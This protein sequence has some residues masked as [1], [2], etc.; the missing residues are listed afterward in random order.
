MIPSSAARRRRAAR[1]RRDGCSSGS[2]S[3]DGEGGYDPRNIDGD[4]DERG[5]WVSLDRGACLA[6]PVRDGQS[7]AP[8]V[9]ICFFIADGTSS[10]NEDGPLPLPVLRQQMSARPWRVR[11][12]TVAPPDGPAVPT[13]TSEGVPRRRPLATLAATTA[14]RRTAAE[15]ALIGVPDSDSDSDSEEMGVSDKPAAT[16]GRPQARPQTRPQTRPQARPQAPPLA[17]LSAAARGL[18]AGGRAPG[19]DSDDDSEFDSDEDEFWQLYAASRGR[20]DARATGR[21]R[22]RPVARP[23]ARPA[24]RP[25]SSGGSPPPPPD[26]AS[27]WSESDESER[28]TGPPKPTPAAPSQPPERPPLASRCVTCGTWSCAT[29]GSV[30][31]RRPWWM[32][33]FLPCDCTRVP[34]MFLRGCR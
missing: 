34:G 28:D 30:S 6:C 23:V 10:D 4:D 25:L 27:D 9:P 18:S 1:P 16:S 22:A 21:P 13:G 17:A 32:V 12:P 2:A 11:V 24:A 15:R 19:G 14:V 8:H 31:A 5:A 3:S 7:R 29:L 20:P 33:R 26:P